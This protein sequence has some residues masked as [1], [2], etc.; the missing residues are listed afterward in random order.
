MLRKAY[1]KINKLLIIISL[2]TVTGVFFGHY[3][4]SIQKVDMSSS[5]AL[6]KN[7]LPTLEQFN[8]SIKITPTE[9]YIEKDQY[10]NE[11]ASMTY[12]IDNL[13]DKAIRK[14][15][16]NSIYIWNSSY[17][18]SHD[19]PI[20]FETTLKPHKKQMI[21]ETILLKRLK[22][23]QQKL[24]RDPDKRIKIEIIARSIEFEDGS[25]IIVPNY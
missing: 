1:M 19:L 2:L 25:A 7:P 10:D 12:Q 23:D 6:N 20:L 11:I 4:Y 14:V 9:R 5:Y 15:H 8:K 3:H 18:Y 16:W 13:S 17:L 24:L 21:S 22:N